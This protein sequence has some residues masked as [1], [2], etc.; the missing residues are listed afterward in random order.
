MTGRGA[1]R[2]A[3]QNVRCEGVD[4]A[5]A[6]GGRDD[7]PVMVLLHGLAARWQT[8]GPL[9]RFLVDDWRIVAPDFRGH[10]S[11]GHAPGTY[12]LPQLVA[13]TQ[14]VLGTLCPDLPVVYGHSLGGWVGLCI[15]AT[16][17][18]S[19][20]IVG[21]TAIRP[22]ATIP[23]QAI[24]YMAG[25]GLALRALA[26][27]QQVMDP[28]VIPELREGLKKPRFPPETVLR[29][30]ACPV[31]L[32]QADEAEGGLMS[33]D[34]V[35]LAVRWLPDCQHVRFDGVGHA[36]HVQDPDRVFGAIDRFLH[37][38]A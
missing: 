31:L 18:V 2:P 29:Q 24:D 7:G 27:A 23:D 37:H 33:D 14:R 38:T 4:V 8:F 12:A 6:V 34:D 26:T 11:S 5:V 25:A 1:L 21:D 19:A 17:P 15:A 16:Q 10:G 35:E 36:L 32:L 20:L 13:D 9:L 30:V 28:A 3:V 22:R